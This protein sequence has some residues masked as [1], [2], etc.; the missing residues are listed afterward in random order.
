MGDLALDARAGSD[1]GVLGNEQRRPV[2]EARAACA[3]QLPLRLGAEDIQRVT[4]RVRKHLAVLGDLASLE[5]RCRV[6]R[7]GVLRPGRHG[8]CDD[9]A[10]GRGRDH[11]SDQAAPVPPR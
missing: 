6:R 10:D 3:V 4:G 11:A 1:H 5:R 2:L 7:F 8:Q 9:P